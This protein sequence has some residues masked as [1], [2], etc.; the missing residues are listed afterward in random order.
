MRNGIFDSSAK[1]MAAGTPESGT[2]T[3]MSAS[4]GCSRARRRPSISRDSFTER[5]KMMLSGREK[6]DGLDSGFGDAQHFAGFDFADVLGVEEIEGAGFA[7]DQPGVVRAV[8]A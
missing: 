5:P 4:T 2:G 1:P 8:L 7:G 3:I 6:M